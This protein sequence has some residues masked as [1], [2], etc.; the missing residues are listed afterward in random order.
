MRDFFSMI[1]LLFRPFF[2]G[3]LEEGIKAYE[4]LDYIKAFKI[5]QKFADKNNPIA[6][7][8]LG[9]MYEKADFVDKDINKA[10]FYFQEASKNN[11]ADAAFA[12]GMIYHRGKDIP[13]DDETAKDYFDLAIVNGNLEAKK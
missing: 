6:Q 1:S 12:L 7:Y 2:G 10:I 11:H 3:T 4:E 13:K 9:K 5:F 8:Y